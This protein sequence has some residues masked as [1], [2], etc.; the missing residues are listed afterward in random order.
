MDKQQRTQYEI[1][2]NIEKAQAIA[3]RLHSIPTLYPQDR[4]LLISL[5]Y[6]LKTAKNINNYEPN[7]RLNLFPP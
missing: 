6:F 2:R 5:Q 1:D 7:A 4:E 3:R